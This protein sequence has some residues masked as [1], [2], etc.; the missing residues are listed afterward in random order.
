MLWLYLD[1]CSFLQCSEYEYIYYELT[2][3]VVNRVISTQQF[4]IR[5]PITLQNVTFIQVRAVQ[6]IQRSIISLVAHLIIL[7]FTVL[8]SIDSDILYNMANSI[9]LYSMT[10]D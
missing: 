8:Y 3:L 4:V 6:T 1:F 7:Y 10:W 5:T 9:Q 2:K